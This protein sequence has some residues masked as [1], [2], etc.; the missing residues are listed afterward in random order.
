LF[1]KYDFTIVYKLGR[2]HVVANALSKL[3][4]IIELI[5]VPNQTIDASVFYIKPEWLN[6]V[7]EFLKT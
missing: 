5:G 6:D 3:L 4:N 1:L 7:K 2:T